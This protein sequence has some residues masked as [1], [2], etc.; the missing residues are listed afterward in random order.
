MIRVVYQAVFV[1]EKG[2]ASVNYDCVCKT[3]RE[4]I[5]KMLNQAKS[6]HSGGSLSATEILV[7]LY[8]G[9]IMKVRP[10]EPEWEGRDRLILSKGHACPAVYSVLAEKGFFPKEWLNTLRKLGSPLQGHPHAARVPGFDCSA[11]S[12]GQG[13]SV[14]NGLGVAFKK[15]GMDNRV[16]CLLG[17]GELQEGQVWEAAMS[18]AHYKLDNVCAIVDYN[19]VQLD[20]TTDEIMALGDLDAKW[21]S[22][23]WNVICC[24]G[25]D[26]EALLAA[27]REAMRCEGRPNVILADTVK[28]KGVSFM[29]NQASWHGAVPN[30]EQ[31]TQALREIWEKK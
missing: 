25:H 22:F 13:L 17:D 27:F 30:E 24:D 26:V 31:L 14:A 5:L 12:L 11:G 7:A 8:F 18:A 15:R 2:E 19:R 3:V 9:G 23:G 1:H 21:S 28:G 6:G 16:Y 10:E 20:G 29:E 4:D